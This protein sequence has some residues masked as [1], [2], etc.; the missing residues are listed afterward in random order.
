[1]RYLFETHYLY[2]LINKNVDHPIS[3]A[4]A[5]FNNKA[6]LYAGLIKRK[7]YPEQIGHQHAT[8]FIWMTG[9]KCDI[10]TIVAN[11]KF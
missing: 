11:I 3:L 4:L 2:R 9:A 10:T 8:Q 7:N 6:F 1:M 5:Y